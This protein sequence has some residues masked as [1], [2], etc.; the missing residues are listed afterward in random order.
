[1]ASTR[2]RAAVPAATTPSNSVYDP[3]SSSDEYDKGSS[4]EEGDSEEG[5]EDDE[6]DEA[7]DE[8]DEEAIFEETFDFQA[9]LIKDAYDAYKVAFAG[10]QNEIGQHLPTIQSTEAMGLK[11]A[12]ELQDI[13]QAPHPPNLNTLISLPEFSHQ[14]QHKFSC[15]ILILQKADDT[16]LVYVGTG[17]DKTKGTHKRFT[18]YDNGKNLS[19]HTK[20]ACQQ[21]YKITHKKILASA[22]VPSEPSLVLSARSLLLVIETALSYKLYAMYNQIITHLAFTNGQWGD[23][24]AYGGLCSHEAWGEGTR[25]SEWFYSGLSQSEIEDIRR[26]RRSEQ[27]KE[28]KERETP[29]EREAR[30]QKQN[31]AARGRRKSETPQEREARPQRRVEENETEEQRKA[32]VEKKRKWEKDSKERAKKRKAGQT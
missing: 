12:D 27:D 19:G 28:R 8:E 6:E 24:I 2:S 11:F 20:I 31:D 21:G 26:Q 10:K 14:D 15:Y 5:E 4:D 32:R 3:P 25:R 13:I 9:T 23:S 1:M 7:Y 18:D 22:P 29:Q 17:T 16:P 30:L